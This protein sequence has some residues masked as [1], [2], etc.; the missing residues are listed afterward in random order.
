MKRILLTIALMCL[1]VAG[2]TAA[3]VKQGSVNEYIY[4]VFS[5]LLPNE[6]FNHP[7][8][9]IVLYNNIGVQEYDRLKTFYQ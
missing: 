4:E 3:G 5:P 6:F 1:V 8:L 7:I 9:N 2:A